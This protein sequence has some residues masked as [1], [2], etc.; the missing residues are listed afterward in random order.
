MTEPSEM[1]I[2]ARL[3]QA[4]EAYSNWGRWGEHDVFGTLNFIDDAK[5]VEA[6]ALI[7]R[8]RVFSLCVPFGADGPQTGIYGRTNPLHAMTRTGLDATAVGTSDRHGLAA[9]DDVIVMALQCST[10]WDGLGHIFSY[11]KSWNGRDAG[12]AVTSAGDH[13]HGMERLA[14]KM[15][16]RGVLLDVGRVC[17][18]DGELPAGYPI[19]EA[20]LTATIA[21]HGPSAQVGRG[22]IVL[23]RTGQL[24][25]RGPGAWGDYVGG[26]APGLSFGTLGWFHDN[27]IAA[28]ACDNFSF[29][30]HPSEY[31]GAIVP[32]H[33][34]LIPHMGMTIGEIW[35]LEQLARDCAADGRYDFF[36]SAA[37]L[38]VTG[39]VGSPVNP[40]AIK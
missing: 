39:A 26:P 29:E 34:V 18:Q 2:E 21:A 13:Y 4:F 37:V 23:I 1:D 33:Q 24:A 7:E 31:P 20:D 30:V 19:T 40:I 38:P 35:N 3:A 32:V 11:G 16:S 8:G 28:A 36:L 17:G 15:V 14:D 5:R 27:E 10:Q 12:Q 25:S 22:D 6:A 9:S